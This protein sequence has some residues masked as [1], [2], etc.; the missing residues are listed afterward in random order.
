MPGAT[1][2]AVSRNTDTTQ[3]VHL[4]VPDGVE[5]PP[6]P[7]QAD[8]WVGHYQRVLLNVRTGELSFFCT[9]WRVHAPIRDRGADRAVWTSQYPGENPNSA[10]PAATQPIPELLMFFI[11]T[12]T[13]VDFPASAHPPTPAWVYLN[14]EQGDAFV[15][16]LVPLAQQLVDN[17]FRVPGTDDL[18]WS[19]E[20]VAAVRAIDAACS[21]YHQ[22]P[23]GVE[24]SLEGVVNFAD[25]VAAAPGLVRREWAEME[26]TAL[27]DAAEGLSR[28]AYHCDPQLR[29]LFGKPYHDGGIELNVY[30]ARSWLYAYRAHEAGNRRRLPGRTACPS[31]RGRP[32]ASP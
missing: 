4:P 5:L 9:D 18:E 26:N 10:V 7:T 16:S 25:A 14:R 17:L 6:L 28:S 30:G 29:E 11:D 12:W 13:R 15:A 19:A 3:V 23:L 2:P 27:D 21:R 31:G 20:S 8:F 24:L 32:G 1:T 22:G